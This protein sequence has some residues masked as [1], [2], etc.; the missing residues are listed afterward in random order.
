ML[1]ITVGI[2]FLLLFAVLI[3]DGISSSY[4]GTS[5]AGTDNSSRPRNSE[6]EAARP[7]SDTSAAIDENRTFSDRRPV[8]DTDLAA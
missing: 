6:V 3:F 5:G 4:A 7:A 1:L 2:A 8:D